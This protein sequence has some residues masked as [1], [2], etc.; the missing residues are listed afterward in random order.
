MGNHFQTSFLVL[1]GERVVANNWALC[2]STKKTE[3]PTLMHRA[4]GM[5]RNNSCAL[6]DEAGML[7]L[8]LS[9]ALD[10]SWHRVFSEIHRNLRSQFCNGIWTYDRTVSIS[11]HILHNITFIHSD[12]KTHTVLVYNRLMSSASCLSCPG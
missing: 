8:C 7:L 5:L 10:L 11:P 4:K 3:F 9:F 6:I 2:L 1:A 12:M